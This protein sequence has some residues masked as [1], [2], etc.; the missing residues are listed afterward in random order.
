M[1]PRLLLAP[2]AAIGA[3][4]GLAGYFIRQVVTPVAHKPDNLMVLDVDLVE[5]EVRLTN[6]PETRVPGK[7]GV[8][9]AG[10]AGHLRVGQ[11]LT[12][13]DHEVVRELLGV[14]SGTPDPGPGRWN[15]Y[16]FSGDPQTS[17][18]LT[19][20]EIELA[21]DLGPVPAWFIPAEQAAK[22]C[23]ILI[24]GLGST[25]QEC[26]RAVRVLHELGLD[27]LIPNYRNDP[28][29]PKHPGKKYQL[30]NYEWQDIDQAI[31]WALTQGAER[32]VLGGWS[33]GGAIA[34]A[35]ARRSSNAD[36][37]SAIFL[38]APVIRWESVLDHHA[39][40]NRVP[41][42]INKLGQKLVQ[43][44]VGGLCLG[45]TQPIRL[46]ELDSL[47]AASELNHPTLLIHSVDDD[48]VPDQP[49][50]ALA[51][52]RPDLIRFISWDQARHTKE[53]NT[54]PQR[55]EQ[56]LREFISSK[57]PAVGGS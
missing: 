25:R 22:E 11:I 41:S 26:L 19:F 21:T 7:Y 23:A 49:S 17:L 57:L 1:K 39:A 33:M 45:L 50:V 9:F 43:T 8:W 32:I 56:L 24:H 30:G 2:A 54:D 37:I 16:Y 34:L 13:H 5:Q 3:A 48:W 36:K 18:G 14:D 15:Q 6:T 12:A 44:K 40:L 27:V 28:G 31:T 47:R 42:M 52:A 55:W 4:V 46:P 53:W 38:D 10:G 51:V 29:A 20:S 35:T